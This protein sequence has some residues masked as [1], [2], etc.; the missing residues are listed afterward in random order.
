[1]VVTHRLFRGGTQVGSARTACTDAP[2][3]VARPSGRLCT[4]TFRLRTGTITARLPTALGAGSGRFTV[5]GG[6]GAFAGA[7]GTG[8]F[9]DSSAT[10]T[11]FSVRLR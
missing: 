5:T 11:A 8:T 9:S 7:R 3:G 4:I 1:V 6:T 2:K 10:R